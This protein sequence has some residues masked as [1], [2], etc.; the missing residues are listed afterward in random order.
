MIYVT[1]SIVWT[2][3]GS[4]NDSPP[5]ASKV[6]YAFSLKPLCFF[7]LT[8][9]VPGEVKVS[10][11]NF[12]HQIPENILMYQIFKRKIPFP[13]ETSSKSF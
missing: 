5:K 2:H 7:E 13:A 6:K 11:A 3:S 8:L 10:L 12:W 9:I 4:S 1:L